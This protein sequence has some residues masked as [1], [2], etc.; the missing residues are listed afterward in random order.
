LVP[1]DFGP[2]SVNP[3]HLTG[4]GGALFQE[5]V[6]RLLAAEVAAAGLSQVTLR[7]SHD[8]NKKDGGVDAE[9]TIVG[10]TDWIPAGDTAWQ[11]KAGTLGPESCAD[12]LDGA[13]FARKIL[14]KDGTY[15]LVLGKRHE[16]QEIAD[17]EAKLREKAEALGF[18]VSGERFKIIEGNQLARWIERFPAL[19]VSP[20]RRQRGPGRDRL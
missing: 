3:D 10:A 6:S 11:F 12:E 2:F 8:T 9:T 1:D 16:A 13:A 19:A 5:L 4:L 17:R 14:E 7:T 18:D 15:R 20:G